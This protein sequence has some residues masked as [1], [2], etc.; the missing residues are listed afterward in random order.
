MIRI[1]II[2]P[3]EIAFRRFLPA[4]KEATEFSYAGVAVASKEEWFQEEVDQ[5]K[6][7]AV[8]GK[9]REKAEEFQKNY[10]GEIF[11]GYE[12]M[13]SSDAI[14]AV[15]LPLPPALHY[16]W[17]KKALSYGKHVFLEKPFATCKKEAMDLITT[18]K[19]K[20][21]ALHENYMFVFHNQLAAI[22]EEI[23]SGSIGDVRLYRVSFGFPRRAA[24]DFRY[25]K[26]LGGGA[27]LDCGGYTLK[28]GNLLLGDTAKV[29]HARKNYTEEFDVDL[30]GS[31]VME[32]DKGDTVQISFGM[33][34]AYKCD[35]E[36]WGSKGTLFTGRVLTAPAGFAPNMTIKTQEGEQIKELP[37][38]DTFLKS[39][40]CFEACVKDAEKRAENY[41]VIE[42][43]AELLEEFMELA[44]R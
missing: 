43:Q 42:R 9:E 1:G 23:E 8:L 11:D 7:D 2:C 34:N 22:N 19:E 28:F 15:Y 14:D 37:A 3:S 16:Q 4:L 35:L 12:A 33:D 29:V 36:V 38:D 31:A 44:G 32:N 27:I 21:L 25:N 39:I 20:G 13:L 26:A 17:A 5:A 10:G 24:G 41:K 30:Y 40:H 18:A 6:A